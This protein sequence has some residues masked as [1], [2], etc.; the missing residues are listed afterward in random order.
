MCVCVCV[1]V[2]VCL[3][4]AFKMTGITL[5]IYSPHFKKRMPACI[6]ENSIKIAKTA[7]EF[8]ILRK[9]SAAVV[10]TN[11]YHPQSS[12]KRIEISGKILVLF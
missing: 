5:N 4:T 6:E 12:E 3:L 10:K 7:R 8:Y 9:K 11:M 2:G 1:Y